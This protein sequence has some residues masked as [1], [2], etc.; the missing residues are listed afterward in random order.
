MNTDVKTRTKGALALIASL[1]L[2][3]SASAQSSAVPGL[4]T[5]QAYVTD[6]SNSPLGSPNPTNYDV[7]FRIYDSATGSNVI[8]AEQQTVTIFEG[9]FSVLLGNG[10]VNGGEPKPDLDQVFTAAERYMGITVDFGATPSEFAPRQRIMTNAYAYRAKVAENVSNQI[11]VSNSSNVGV[12]TNSPFRELHV[13]SADNDTR[14]LLTHSGTG[15]GNG[16]GFEVGSNN[17]SGWLW[18]YE[19]TALRFATNDAER[20]R[21]MPDGKVGIGTSNPSELLHVYAGSDPTLLLQ[22]NGTNEVSGKV[23]MRQSNLSGFDIYYDGTSA[24]DGLVFES[25]G[26]G[27]P[28]GKAMFIKQSTLDVGVN[29]TAPSTN[30]HVVGTD[31]LGPASIFEIAT[32]FDNDYSEMIRVVNSG[33]NGV[34]R[35]GIGFSNSPAGTTTTNTPDVYIG[36]G[37]G[38]AGSSSN[39]F[40][41]TSKTGSG[42]YDRNLALY[43][44][45]DTK[46]TGFGMRPDTAA[47]G[48]ALEIESEIADWD[49]VMVDTSD[50]N[51]NVYKRAGFRN[52]PSGYLDAYNRIEA[53]GGQFARLNSN[54]V[55]TVASDRRVKKEIEPRDDMLEIAL[56]MQPVEYFYKEEDPEVTDKHLGF[57]AQDVEE[58][59]PNAVSAGSDLKTLG[60]GQLSTVAIGAVKEQHAIVQE[61]GERI[62]DLEKENAELRERLERIEKLLGENAAR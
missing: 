36:T 29:T 60:Y 58:L 31:N 6:S 50:A 21:I 41:I 43:I 12:G 57:I 44:D 3:L 51:G 18:N 1:A 24:F 59:I 16:N 48:G 19:N 23:A 4:M 52:H 17:S 37:Y 54:G 46:K 5:Y 10:Q 13:S 15:T 61:Q 22:S 25:Y 11:F 28:A 53:G 20:M 34:G 40:L 2:G 55:W 35:A 7:T 62:G 33:A 30:L 14:L 9:N 47:R 39:D 38:A 32:N 42:I 56:Q 8:W 49:I 26:S 27:A 45:G